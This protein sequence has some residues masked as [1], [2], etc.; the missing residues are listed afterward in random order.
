MAGHFGDFL[1]RNDQRHLNYTRQVMNVDLKD[2]I[3]PISKILTEIVIQHIMHHPST[4][5][6]ATFRR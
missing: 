1:Q 6:R 5:G 4:C 3:G 2:H